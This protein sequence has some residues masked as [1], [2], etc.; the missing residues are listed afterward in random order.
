MGGSRL[1]Q[2]GADAL[3]RGT[4]GDPRAAAGQY[5][6]A[7]AMRSYARQQRC[8]PVRRGC[9]KG[10]RKGRG[11]GGVG[12]QARA[13]KA[14]RKQQEPPEGKADRLTSRGSAMLF[15]ARSFRSAADRQAPIRSLAAAPCRTHCTVC[16]CSM[17]R[18]V[19]T[20]GRQRVVCCNSHGVC[21]TLHVFYAVGCGMLHVVCGVLHVACCAW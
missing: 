5:V 15:S 10:G 3:H 18:A 4:P 6:R 1:P 7:C 16:T 9:V 21:C 12:G 14:T 2:P 17:Q 8:E 19:A 20:D 11:K 13:V